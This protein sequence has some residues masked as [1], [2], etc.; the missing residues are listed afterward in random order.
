MKLV[1]VVAAIIANDNKFLCVQ[2]GESKLPYISK[3]FEFP[4]GKIENGETN[5]AA[6]IREISEEL[7]LEIH[8][9]KHFLTVEHSYPD[10]KITMHSYKCKADDPI[11]KLS[12]HIDFKWRTPNEMD[13]LDWAEADIPIVDKL[14][15]EI[16]E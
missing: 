6:L 9:L 4:G 10:F 11:L 5:E 1:E 12:E 14:K 16:N 13:D 2:R 8:S 7:S 3:K 15:K